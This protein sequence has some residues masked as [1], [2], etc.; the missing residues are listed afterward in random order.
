MYFVPDFG[1]YFLHIT[2]HVLAIRVILV[3]RGFKLIWARGF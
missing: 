2:A 1:K 3:L